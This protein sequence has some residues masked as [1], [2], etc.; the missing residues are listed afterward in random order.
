MVLPR[1]VC[2]LLILATAAC[3]PCTGVLNCGGEWVRYESD[4]VRRDSGA[5]IEGARVEFVRTAGVALES[6]T[7]RTTTDAGGRFRIAAH[8][9]GGGE[10]E[11]VLRFYDASGTLLDAGG[12]VLTTTRSANDYRYLGEWR[13]PRLHAGRYGILYWRAQDAR[14]AGIQVEFRRTGGV[15]TT[16]ESFT[17]QTDS[18]GRFPF[19]A[20]PLAEGTLEGELRVQ[21][22]APYNTIELREGLRFSVV[23]D[24]VYG[25]N[26]GRWGIGPQLP[27]AGL[28]I[29]GDTKQ[30]AEGVALEFQRTGGVPI[31]P[32]RVVW[33][34][35]SDGFANV[36]LVPATPLGYGEVVGDLTI[37]PPAP[38]RTLVVKE[39]RLATVA[40]DVASFNRIAIW[41]LGR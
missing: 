12:I 10:I 16:K 26:A 5:P 39:L 29:W 18:L 3:D 41:E 13:M 35:G 38:Y 7:L 1:T 11:G 23:A 15:P 34:S 6:D 9:L 33:K 8:A 28:L 4:F 40:R 27:Y 17:A 14:A 32:D 25:E 21:L 30:P 19:L 31:S 36:R 24:A 37:R 22:P 2:A 20:V